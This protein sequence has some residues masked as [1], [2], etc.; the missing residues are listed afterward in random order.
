M[1][2]IFQMAGQAARRNQD[3]IDTQ[4]VIRSGKSWCQ[5]FGSCSD[6]CQSPSVDR[7]CEACRSIARLDLDKYDRT[8]APGNQ[9]DFADAHARPCRKDT[10]PMQPQPPRCQGLRTTATCFGGGALQVFSFIASAR[11]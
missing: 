5:C 8:S 4:R 10:P 9:I 11:A 6:P 3:D 7:Q 2:D 1:P